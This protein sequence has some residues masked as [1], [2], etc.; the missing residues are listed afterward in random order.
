M[1][2]SKIYVMALSLMFLDLFCNSFGNLY[3]LFFVQMELTRNS[4]I[5]ISFFLQCNFTLS[6]GKCCIVHWCSLSRGNRI[7]CGVNRSCVGSLETC[8]SKLVP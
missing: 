6:T 5:H 3:F 2:S 7:K 1:N 8:P 4:E